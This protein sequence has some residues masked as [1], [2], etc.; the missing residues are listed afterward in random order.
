MYSLLNLPDELILF[1]IFIP[2]SWIH[3]NLYG[4]YLVVGAIKELRLVLADSPKF[5]L[6]ISNSMIVILEVRLS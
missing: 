4:Q 5:K 6:V 2:L 1:D 3:Q